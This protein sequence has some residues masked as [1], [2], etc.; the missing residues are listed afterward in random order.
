MAFF[1][2]FI[3]AIR[4]KPVYQLMVADTKF[5]R[6]WLFR[7]VLSTWGTYNKTLSWLLSKQVKLTFAQILPFLLNDRRNVPAHL[8]SLQ[9]RFSSNTCTKVKLRD[10]QCVLLIASIVAAAFRL[11]ES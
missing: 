5:C 10:R 8:T 6:V 7:C 11:V 1:G 4:P 2:D 3:L 9:L